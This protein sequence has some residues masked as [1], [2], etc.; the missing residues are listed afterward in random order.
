MAGG[1]S[2]EMKLLQALVGVLRQEALIMDGMV[3]ALQYRVIVLERQVAGLQDACRFSPAVVVGVPP[4]EEPVHAAIGAR[5]SPKAGK[6]A[7][8]GGR[9]GVV[10]GPTVPPR[11]DGK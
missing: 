4:G 10:L 7:G 9:R 2:S 5:P 11:K 8:G 3:S 1:G 6:P